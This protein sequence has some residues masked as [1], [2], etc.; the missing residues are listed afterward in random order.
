MDVGEPVEI[1]MTKWPQQPHWVY[2]GHYLGS[3]EHGDWVGI[4]RGTRMSRPG[5]VFEAPVDQV[6]LVPGP[7]PEET[8]G[9]CAAF[10]GDG[11]AGHAQAPVGIY[12]DI[13]T[14]P[15]WDGTTAH[16]VD[17]DLDVV[18]GLSGRVWVDDEDEFA[19]H[20]VSLG[21]PPDV[22]ELALRSCAH[23]HAAVT[24][25]IPPFDGS[26]L[27]WLEQVPR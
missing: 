21:Y 11:G 5:A 26:H 7:G 18:R 16:A 22:V 17:L 25:G 15:V 14:P 20:R 10:Y 8:R 6:C 13:A 4:P 19:A 12:V 1:V 24:G 2:P 9:W 3:D 23:V 27:A